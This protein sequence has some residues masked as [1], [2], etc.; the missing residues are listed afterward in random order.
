MM[1]FE[2]I[3]QYATDRRFLDTKGYPYNPPPH[4]LLDAHT[5]PYIRTT[6]GE[7]PPHPHLA[8]GWGRISRGILRNPY[9]PH[10]VPLL[11]PLPGSTL[12]L[13]ISFFLL[14]LTSHKTRSRARRESKTDETCRRIPLLPPFPRPPFLNPL[15]PVLPVTAPR[16]P[17]PQRILTPVMQSPRRDERRPLSYLAL[18]HRDPCRTDLSSLPL[19]PLPDLLTFRY[20]SPHLPL[21]PPALLTSF[22]QTVPSSSLPSPPFAIPLRTSTPSYSHF[23]PS[24]LDV[25]LPFPVLSSSLRPNSLPPTYPAPSHPDPPP[26]PPILSLHPPLPYLPYHLVPSC[27]PPSREFS[28]PPSLPPSSPLLPPSLE[29]PKER[30]HPDEHTFHTFRVSCDLQLLPPIQPLSSHSLPLLPRLIPNVPPPLIL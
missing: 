18:C 11:H 15:F 8:E 27:P 10:A 17:H 12:F 26:L 30:D 7:A 16:P 4:D 29:Y 28:S 13:I 9:S 22:P 21:H 25:P 5:I 24:L 20:L 23:L 6:K 14:P 3:L 19:S 2:L 1:I